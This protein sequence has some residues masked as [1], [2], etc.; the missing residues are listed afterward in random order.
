MFQDFEVILGPVGAAKALHLL[1]P[2]F[3]P[4]WD[5]AIA[6]EY[7]SY[8]LPTGQNG[9]QCLKFMGMV[10]EQVTRIVSQGA[11]VNSAIKRLDEY[12]Y[13]R[14]TKKWSIGSW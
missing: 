13:C 4:L 11:D 10:Q 3:F 6:V 7:V 12:N 9:Q 8:L 5:R 2:A 14:Y 1:A